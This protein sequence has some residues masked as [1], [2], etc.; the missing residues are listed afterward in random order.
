LIG[1]SPRGIP[2]NLLPYIYQVALQNQPYLVVF[3]DDYP[4]K[5]GT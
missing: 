5:D 3:G 1:E 2:N 4:T